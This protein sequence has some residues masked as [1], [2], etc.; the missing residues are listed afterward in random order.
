MSE[1][2]KT[3]SILEIAK[4]ALGLLPDA[5]NRAYA[6]ARLALLR[7][8]SPR[9]LGK[10]FQE[11][12]AKHGQRVFLKSGDDCWT[13]AKANAV[14][15]QMARAYLAMGVQ[16]GDVVG[17]LSLNR[18]ETL[19]ATIACAK[20]A[21][22]AALLNTNQTG[23]VLLHSLRVV[24]PRLLLACDHGLA[25]LND[26]NGMDP[27]FVKGLDILALE[28]EPSS[29]PHSCFRSAWTGQSEQNL[30]QTEEIKAETAC[31]YVFTSGTTGL[32]KASV[33]SHYR[34]LQA[35]NGMNCAVQLTHSDTLYCC[36]PLYHNNALT[37]CLGLVVASGACMALD[38]KFS[39][40]RFW[41][42]I[43]HYRATSFAYIGELLRY[44]LNQAENMH[45]Q[46]HEVRLILGNGLR[47]EIWQDF[48]TRFGIK[49]I[50][51][52]YGA[53]ESNLGFM[54]A[55]G[56][57]ETVGFCPMPF[58]VIEFD[59]ETEEI[60][61]NSKGRCKS[62]ARGGVGL[63]ISEVTSLRPFDG[64][65]DSQANEKKLLRDVFK[66]GDCWFNSGDLVRRQGWHHVQFVDRLG[67][68][69]RWKGENVATSQVEGVIG[70]LSWVEHAIV[71]GVRVPGQDGR[72]GMAAITVKPGE[73]ADL[74]ELAGWVLEQLPA[75]AVPLYVRMPD[76]LD[77]TATFKYNKVKLKREGIETHHFDDALFVLNWATRR[78]EAVSRS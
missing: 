19:L 58:E 68:T 69:F 41:Q 75:Y 16:A 38:E 60:Q 5:H 49:Q 7:P 24:K 36:L 39:A 3:V 34:W 1:R 67:D 23:E 29:M 6:L 59:P 31:F 25:R 55:F 4:G 52:F 64:Y 61:R 44:L 63:L 50:Y 14:A 35:A 66:K 70:K 26:L 53:S 32:P 12:A 42:R 20:I 8:G 40:S 45:D 15:N 30:A 71:Y 78:Y 21:A 17:V 46:N 51:E 43:A 10:M 13:Y 74:G 65:T 57:R 62:V 9:S 56:L 54:N 27:Q 33:M 47:P 22:V 18:A 77:T 72:A 76:Y 2:S 73:Q 28:S 37:V 48:E 11:T